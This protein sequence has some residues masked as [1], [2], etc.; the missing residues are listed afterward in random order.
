[1]RIFLI[2]GIFQPFL[3]PRSEILPIQA[4]LHTPLLH[5]T[6]WQTTWDLLIMLTTMPIVIPLIPALLM[7]A[8]MV[9]LANP[10]G[11]DPLD[12]DQTLAT[13]VIVIMGK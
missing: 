8:V 12:M 6:E 5:H 9:V 3:F 2:F 4:S 10:V 7:A 11:T 1:M 13:V